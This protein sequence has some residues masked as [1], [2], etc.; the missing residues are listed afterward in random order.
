MNITIYVYTKSEEKNFSVI[1][2]RWD[3][4]SA[5]H[6]TV[7]RIKIPRCMYCKPRKELQFSGVYVLKTG[8][9][10]APHYQTY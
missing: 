10:S 9:G 4:N 7:V 6:A 8:L 3:T 1:P 5:V 2:H